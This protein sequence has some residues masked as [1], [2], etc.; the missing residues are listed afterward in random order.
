MTCVRERWDSGRWDEAHWDGQLC[1]EA[2]TGTITLA[3]QPIGVRCARGFKAG[4]GAVT[5]TGSSVR[6]ASTR[7]LG[8]SSGSIVLS[9]AAVT[10]TKGAAIKGLTAGA[11][12]I[13]LTGYAVTLTA[14]APLPQVLVAM[15]GAFL[16][17]GNAVV[18]RKPVPPLPPPGELHMGRRAYIPNRW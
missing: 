16:M 5:L 6:L 12:S 9:G 8:V 2:G 13:V 11:G 3:G 7:G 15:P 17:L 4:A 18:L 1:F 14:A 10:L